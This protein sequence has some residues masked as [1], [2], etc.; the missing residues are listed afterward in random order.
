M[1]YSLDASFLEIY[2][3]TIRD[4]LGDGREDA[5]HEIKMSGSKNSND[6]FVTN[7]TVVRVTKEEMVIELHSDQSHLEAINPKIIVN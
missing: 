5:K 3:E 7:L 1:Q 2:N 4:L 6:V